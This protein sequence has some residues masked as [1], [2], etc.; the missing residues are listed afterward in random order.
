VGRDGMGRVAIVSCPLADRSC[1][2]PPSAVESNVM[3][4]YRVMSSNA[5]MVLRT[6]ARSASVNGLI[7]PRPSRTSKDSAR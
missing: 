2:A 1:G 5:R 6:S 7:P 3:A 4:G